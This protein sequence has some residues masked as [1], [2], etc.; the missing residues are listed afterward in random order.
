[1]RDILTAL[2]GLVIILLTAALVAPPLIDW[3]LRRAEVDRALSR[4]AGAPIETAGPLDVRLLPSP[5]I[6]VG[7]LAIGVAGAETATLVA[8]DVVAEI[9]LAPLLRGEVRFSTGRA[10]Q[11]EVRL[12]TRGDEGLRLPPALAPGART[13]AAYAF[14]DLRAERLSVVVV[15]PE[16]GERR[17]A[18]LSDVRMS[19]DALGGPY[20]IDG[21][22]QGVPFRL[23]SGRF[24]DEGTMPVRF[25]AGGDDAPVRFD[26]E[27]ALTLEETGAGFYSGAVAGTGRLVVAG[28]EPETPPLTATAGFQTA[29]GGVELAEL[30][31]ETGEPGAG[32]RL[33]GSGFVR[34]DDPRLS[35]VLSTRRL[36]LDRVL[37]SPLGRVLGE[38][39]R[40]ALPFPVASAAL[41]RNNLA[42]LGDEMEA[43]GIERQIGGRGQAPAVMREATGLRRGTRTLCFSRRGRR[44]GTTPARLDGRLEPSL[45]TGQ[46]TAG[47]ISAR[48]DEKAW[49]R[50]PSAHRISLDGQSPIDLRSASHLWGPGPR[51]P[52]R[53]CASR[54]GPRRRLTER[55]CAT[56]QAPSA[57]VGRSN[58]ADRGDA[59]STLAR[60]PQLSALAG[61]CRPD[62]RPSPL[63]LDSRRTSL[64]GR[65]R[66]RDGIPRD[67][68]QS[69][70]ATLVC[71]RRSL[72]SP[73]L[74]RAAA[75]LRANRG[76]HPTEDWHGAA[77]AGRLVAVDGPEAAASRA[78]RPGRTLGDAV[79]LIPASSGTARW[80]A[81]P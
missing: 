43:V 9:E 29:L 21:V 25:T 79:A 12:P 27:A 42:L 19:A 15:S 4:A 22:A 64:R 66:P 38:A 69:A 17:L 50:A 76:T 45:R 41:R 6:T 8:Q 47:A 77:S 65:R 33:D 16:M 67:A 31:I 72:D 44:L 49:T 60:L 18:R 5:R 10:A 36:V 61:P 51:R 30:A 3:D 48:S 81:P 32:T 71:P 14:E 46:R 75:G 35:L 53:T 28:A 37:E 56:S 59:R 68:L 26:A 54:R 63:A 73:Y 55:S 20:R 52:L 23:V 58:S 39:G 70:R 1:M 7:R 62:D 40:G 24:D 57:S 2:A 11:A 80:R 78:P 13:G 34:L 74:R